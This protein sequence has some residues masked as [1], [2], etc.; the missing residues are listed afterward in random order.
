MTTM[1][2]PIC[3]EPLDCGRLV[4]DLDGQQQLVH[5]GD[6]YGA[7]AHFEVAELEDWMIDA[8]TFALVRARGRLGWVALGQFRQLDPR[9]AQAH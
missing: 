5:D 9:T 2:C 4:Y 1:A 3:H 8:S 7:W 6:C